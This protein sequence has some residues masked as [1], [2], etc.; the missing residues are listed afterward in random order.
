MRSM[1]EVNATDMSEDHVRTYQMRVHEIQLLGSGHAGH[2]IAVKKMC[3][4]DVSAEHNDVGNDKEMRSVLDGRQAQNGTEIRDATS[5]RHNHFESRFRSC[6]MLEDKKTHNRY[7]SQSRKAC[8]QDS[9]DDTNDD[10][11]CQTESQ[12]SARLCVAQLTAWWA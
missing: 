1:N 12:N 6:R 3:E 2:M 7:R 9:V 5:S 4:V 10:R 11:I 8:D